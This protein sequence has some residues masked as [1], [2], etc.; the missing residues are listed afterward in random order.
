MPKNT[1]LYSVARAAAQG[2][3]PGLLCANMNMPTLE[4]PVRCRSHKPSS[5]V[6]CNSHAHLCPSMLHCYDRDCPVT[7]AVASTRPM[8]GTSYRLGGRPWAPC[9]RL[10]R[11]EP[12]RAHARA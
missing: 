10:K 3:G 5:P 1:V 2:T 6:P 8:S 7:V 12:V 4:T 11:K 9:V